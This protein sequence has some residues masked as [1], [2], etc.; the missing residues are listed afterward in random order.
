MIGPSESGG[1]SEPGGPSTSNF[2]PAESTPLTSVVAPGP[3]LPVLSPSV[4]PPV[5]DPPPVI[6]PI[7]DIPFVNVTLPPALTV[8]AAVSLSP[9]PLSPQPS[10]IATTPPHAHARE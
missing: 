7:D 9:R 5:G 10:N 6:V 8:T 4:S 2:G 3:P 1:T